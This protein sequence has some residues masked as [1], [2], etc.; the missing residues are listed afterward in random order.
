MWGAVVA[1][2]YEMLHRINAVNSLQGRKK[3]KIT[4]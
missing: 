4:P 2:Q 1:L 3:G